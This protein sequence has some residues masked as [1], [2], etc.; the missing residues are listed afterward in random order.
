MLVDR[1]NVH[2]LG[3]ARSG[4]RISAGAAAGDPGP[5]GK[6]L[7]TVGCATVIVLAP[8]FVA[9]N[10]TIENSFDYIAALTGGRYAPTGPNGAQAV[11]VMLDKGADRSLFD[12]VDIIGHVAEQPR[13]GV[14]ESSLC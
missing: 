14:S 5:D 12:A 10:L 13:A 7:G 6:P 9:H 11:A 4:T 2:L 3:A 1:P 8:G